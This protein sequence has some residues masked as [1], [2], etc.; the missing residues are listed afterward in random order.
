[1][2]FRAVAPERFAE[3]CEPSLVKIA[4]TLEAEPIDDTHS[5]LRTQ[6]RA[7]ATDAASAR[8]L[9]RYWR[10]FGAGIVLIRWLGLRAVR[11]T[12]ERRYRAVQSLKGT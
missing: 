12:A 5:R 3:F 10:L 7:S 4:W 8:R 1:V 2:S 9:T 6:T 11:R